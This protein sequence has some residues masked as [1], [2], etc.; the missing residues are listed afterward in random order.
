MAK[1]E[2]ATTK[3][4]KA[5][6]AVAFSRKFSRQYGENLDFSARDARVEAYKVLASVENHSPGFKALRF[7]DGSVDIIHVAR[8]L[9]IHRGGI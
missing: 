9:R 6:D 5:G 7:E 4:L 3:G 8:R 1:T 2:W